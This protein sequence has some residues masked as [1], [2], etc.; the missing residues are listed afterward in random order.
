M[1]GVLS[2]F[3]DKLTAAATQST[4]SGETKLTASAE[5]ALIRQGDQALAEFVGQRYPRLSNRRSGGL[6]G[7]KSSFDAGVSAGTNLNLHRGV[8][9]RSGSKGLL[10][11]G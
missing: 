4:E 11:K 1:L 8:T 3:S 7:D 10:L 6:R 2:G 9:E 5:R